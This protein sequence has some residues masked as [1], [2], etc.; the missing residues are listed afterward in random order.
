M[1]VAL[2]GDI[3]DIIHSFREES[4]SDGPWDLWVHMVLLPG[5]LSGDGIT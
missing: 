5:S 1:L 3:S 2:T 4:I